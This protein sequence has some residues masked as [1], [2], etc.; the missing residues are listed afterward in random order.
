MC[1]GSALSTV[2]AATDIYVV[3]TYY[4]SAALNTQADI[5]LSLI[6]T[7]MFFQC[8]T[9]FTQHGSNIFSLK[10]LGEILITFLFLRPIV[11]AYRVST[12]HQ[13]SDAPMDS[14]MEYLVNKCTELGTES[15]PGCILQLYVASESTETTSERKR[16]AKQ[17][18]KRRVLLFVASLLVVSLF[19]VSLLVVSISVTRSYS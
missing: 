10:G 18:A 17:G 16:S 15:I 4:Q 11:D 8:T 2:D 5:M 14:L 9:L 7:N 6:A 3:S 12:N 1:L 13:Q 19:V